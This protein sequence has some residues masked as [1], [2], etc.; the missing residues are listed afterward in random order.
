MDLDHPPFDAIILGCG[1][2][3]S[4]A[5]ASLAHS[6]KTVLHVDENEYY[7]GD[8]ASLSLS[9][10]ISWAELRSSPSTEEDSTH[11]LNQKARFDDLAWSFPSSSSSDTSPPLPPTLKQASRNYSLYLSPSLVPSVSPLIQTLV[12]SGVSRYSTFRILESTSIYDSKLGAGKKVPGS[13]ED[14]FKDKEVGLV[15]KRR[16]MKVLLWCMGEFEGSNEIEG[17]E[18]MPLF[19][20]L[21][22]SFSLSEDLARALT[23]ALAHCTSASDPA[24]P[25]LIRARSYLRS[26]GKYGN[27]AFLVGQYGG[28]GE[29]AQGFCRLSAVHGAIYI[30][31]HPITSIDFPSSSSSSDATSTST[32]SHPISLQI[33][34]FTHPI[35]ASHLIVSP[36]YL[37]P[38]PTSLETVR[39][40][41]CI[42]ILDSYP[43]IFPLPPPTA[44]SPE[45]SDR[46]EAKEEMEVEK[47]DTSLMVFP[48][49]SLGEESDVDVKETVQALLVGEGTGSCP[50]GQYILY[51]TL[52]LPS[53]PSLTNTTNTSSPL[54]PFLTK[55][56]SSSPN[57]IQ[58]IFQITYTQTCLS[59]PS[60]PNPNAHV[61]IVRGPSASSCEPE[62]EEEAGRTVKEAERLFWAVVGKEEFAEGE[63]EER[64]FFVPA[65]EQ[66]EGED[67]DGED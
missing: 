5:A 62:M 8:Y 48:P 13:K 20:F 15:D 47:P 52:P 23:F 16:L 12:S 22:T 58:P 64:G 11:L 28:A 19:D 67:G 34:G 32:P 37:P 42:A 14:V 30:L 59:P 39:F 66:Q 31:S 61:H 36:D 51:L 27:S 10:L 3:E 24:L 56:L 53:N 44:A 29:I 35:L 2:P 40:A 54:L 33:K 38:S 18:Q 43:S 50:R 46:E 25:S 21:R 63:G 60:N 7:G 6:G 55:I 26:V 9:E 49:G 1:L 45:D 17:K 4:I 65:V 57:P 41:R